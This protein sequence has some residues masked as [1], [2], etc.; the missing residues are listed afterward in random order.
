[1]FLFYSTQFSLIR[2]NPV[3]LILRKHTCYLHLEQLAKEQNSY[4]LSKE[5]YF[6]VTNNNKHNMSIL[7]WAG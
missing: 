3:Q 7:M 6:C 5:L 1:M 2:D 4:K